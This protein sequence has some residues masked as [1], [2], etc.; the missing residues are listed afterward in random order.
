MNNIKKELNFIFQTISRIPV[1]DDAVDAMAVARAK[2][3]QV[4]AAL[5]K[6]EQEQTKES[7][8][9]EN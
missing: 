6:M 8:K 9:K 4:Y 5:E 2:L 7:E 3:R 1:T